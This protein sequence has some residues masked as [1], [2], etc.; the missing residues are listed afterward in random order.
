MDVGEPPH[1]P[2]HM[3]LDTAAV[4]PEVKS[5][6]GEIGHGP[7]HLARKVGLEGHPVQIGGEVADGLHGQDAR[8]YEFPFQPDTVEE[9]A[10]LAEGRQH[11]EIPQVDVGILVLDVE[12][13]HEDL[14]VPDLHLAGDVR[15][16]EAGRTRDA[17]VVRVGEDFTA[18][19]QDVG[20]MD[21]RLHL[22]VVPVDDAVGIGFC[23]LGRHPL[24]AGIVDHPEGE[25]LDVHLLCFQEVA[26]VLFGFVGVGGE[27]EDAGEVVRRFAVGAGFEDQVELPVL[28][29][30]PAHGDALLAEE[31]LQGEPGGELADAEEGVLRRNGSVRVGGA[32]RQD[33]ILERDRIEGTDGDVPHGNVPVDLVGEHPDR[34]PGEGGLHRR[35]LDGDDQAQQQ[36]QDC[37]QD[38]SRYA[39]S[40]FH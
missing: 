34:L 27:A 19:H 16:V 4:L 39:K 24:A 9:V 20:G 13:V 25:V 30:E 5:L 3:R 7:F 36:N 17:D 33:D 31:A 37:R 40:L 32:V 38:P 11:A 8:G 26:E 15:E 22:H 21:L 18:A 1:R 2:V 14:P 23:T 29:G 10:I 12:V 28:Q 35:R 6:D